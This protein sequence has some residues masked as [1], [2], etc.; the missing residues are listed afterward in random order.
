MRAHRRMSEGCG[1]RAG[2]GGE[3]ARSFTKYDWISPAGGGGRT[4]DQ[5][6][7]SCRLQKGTKLIGPDLW[8]SATFLDNMVT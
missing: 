5:F 6:Y 4:M 8:F 1:G 7:C 2:G 3:Q